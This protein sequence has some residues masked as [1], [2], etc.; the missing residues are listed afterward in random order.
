[1]LWK[2]LQKV[3]KKVPLGKNG[4]KVLDFGFGRVKFQGN[5]TLGHRLNKLILSIWTIRQNAPP[6]I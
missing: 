1:M 6:Q 5:L 2:S 4:G 3:R